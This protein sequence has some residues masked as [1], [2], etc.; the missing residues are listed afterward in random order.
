MNSAR[1]IECQ[2]GRALL[3]RK[4]FRQQVIKHYHVGLFEDLHLVNF[5]A[6]VIQQNGLLARFGF[7]AAQIDRRF[8]HEGVILRYDPVG[9][10]LGQP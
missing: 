3:R 8:G 1:L 7:I 10:S 5:S 6:R 9:V 4:A 2:V